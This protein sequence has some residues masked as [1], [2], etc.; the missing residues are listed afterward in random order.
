M[1]QFQG[2]K[3]EAQKRIAGKLGYTGDMSNFDG[4]LEQNPDAK[5]KMNM[6]NQQAVKMMQ[7]GMVRKNFANGGVAEF[8]PRGGFRAT[9]E[10]DLK[11]GEPVNKEGNGIG[12]LGVLGDGSQLL[13]SGYQNYGYGNPQTGPKYKIISVSGDQSLEFSSFQD[14]MSAADPRYVKDDTPEYRTPNENFIITKS[15]LQN[16]VDTG[17]ITQQEFDNAYF[18][19]FENFEQ[20][21]T[22]GSP[23]Y[24]NRLDLPEITGTTLDLA[25]GGEGGNTGTTDPKGSFYTYDEQGNRT[26]APQQGSAGVEGVQLTQAATNLQTQQQAT[27]DATPAFSPSSNYNTQTGEFYDNSNTYGTMKDGSILIQS[28]DTFQLLNPSGSAVVQEFSNFQEAMNFADPSANI[29][30]AT[31]ATDN[32]EATGTNTTGNVDEQVVGQPQGETIPFGATTGTDTNQGLEGDS[33]GVVNTG[34]TTGTAVTGSTGTTLTQKDDTVNQPVNTSDITGTNQAIPTATAPVALTDNTGLE[35]NQNQSMDAPTTIADISAGR[36]VTPELPTGTAV[37]A[38]GTAVTGQQI[39]DNTAG[40]VSGNV[41]TNVQQAA[42]SGAGVAASTMGTS[43][44]PQGSVSKVAGSGLTNALA[45]TQEAVGAVDPRATVR[46]ATDTTTAVSNLRAD[47]ARSI[48]VSEPT[49]RR[50]Q[51]GELVTGSANAANAATFTEKVQAK[52]ATPTAKATVEGQLEQLMS[53][54]D[55][56]KTPVWASGAM[57]AATAAMAQRGLGASSMAGQAIVQAAMEASLPIAIADAQT[58]ASFEAQNLSNKQERAMLSAQQRATFMGQEFDQKFQA[59]VMNASKISEI[60]NTNLT[61]DQQIALENSRAANTV[62]LA[63]LS[64]DQALTLSEA[65]ALSNLEIANLS[66]SQQAVVLNAQNL[67]QMDMANLTNAQQTSMFKGQ[68]RTAA[69]FSDAAALNAAKQFNA[70]SKNQA[71]QFFA[72]LKTQNSQFNVAQTNGINQYNAGEVNAQSRFTSEMMNQREQFNANNKLVVE[73]SN[74]VWR[75]EIGTADTAAI[76]RTNELNASALLDVSNTAYNNM[77]QYYADTMEY[78][79]TSANDE[80]ERMTELAIAKLQVDSTFDIAKWQSSAASSAAIGNAMIK[81]AT[82]DFDGDTLLERGV[83]WLVD[84]IT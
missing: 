59:R 9:K 1:I 11:S 62:N 55:G 57:R 21:Q 27:K 83:D 18:G 20:Y 31:T 34:T 2:F 45:T 69:I 33:I 26:G 78:A 53:D 17:T 12:Q 71:D 37:E 42:Q 44:V 67:M 40:A 76:N 39:V 3:P 72:N 84:T 4:Y 32:L 6:Y 82:T 80:R 22:A 68:Q 13:Y 28:G 29:T 54:F 64:N 46:A 25:Y 49:D 7:G 51:S 10:I 77:W 52:T 74:A 63:N 60:A 79:F 41:N 5:Q 81:I 38:V 19:K 58:F 35:V 30:A 48:D 23:S 43:T 14:A 15:K 16:D 47:D 75:R 56:G 73:Q 36:V 65:A 50:L 66:N 8:R 24:N 70:T 61:A